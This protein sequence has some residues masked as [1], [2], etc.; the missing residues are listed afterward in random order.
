[1]ASNP[2]GS[3]RKHAEADTYWCFMLL[4]VQFRDNFVKTLDNSEM[5]INALMA[6]FD[7][8][9]EPSPIKRPGLVNQLPQYLSNQV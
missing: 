4:L 9:S 1:M 2:D 7:R 3:W 5:G 8:V 6:Q